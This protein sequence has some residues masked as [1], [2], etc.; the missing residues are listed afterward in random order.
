MII[1]LSVRV[2]AR[3]LIS[4]CSMATDSEVLKVGS[5]DQQRQPHLGTC[6]TCSWAGPAPD[7]LNQKPGG[8]NPERGPDA[9]RWRI[10]FLSFFLEEELLLWR[11]GPSLKDQGGVGPVWGGFSS[12]TFCLFY[13]LLV[14]GEGNSNALEDSCMGSPT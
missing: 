3:G 12:L 4:P 1:S 2:S 6:Q 8:G 10:T 13:N 7:L 14:V 11:W 9:E 5:L